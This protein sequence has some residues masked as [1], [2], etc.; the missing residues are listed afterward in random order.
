MSVHRGV[1]TYKAEL[2]H[3]TTVYSV[4]LLLCSPCLELLGAKRVSDVLNRVT[5]TVG[6]V[7]GRV[8][9]PLVT[10]VGMRGILDP[11][12]YRVLL[13]IF[14][15]HLHTQSGLGG[16]KRVVCLFLERRVVGRWI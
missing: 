10:G 15:G 5:E 1:L 14:Q 16:R 7:I 2:Y 12:C 6:V 3:Y 13:S 9:T 4:T 11:V 8:N